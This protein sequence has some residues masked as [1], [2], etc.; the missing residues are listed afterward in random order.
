MPSKTPRARI[1]Q[2]ALEQLA[3]GGFATTSLR[4]V[5][6]KAGCT[7]GSV[8]HHFANREAL[9]VAMLREAHEAAAGRMVQRSQ[10]A[11]SPRARL[12]AVLEE[13][14]PFDEVRVREWRVWLA[15]WSEAVHV[16]ALADEHQR[17]YAEWKVL[18]GAL[19]APLVTT[20]AARE[21]AVGA[22]TALVDGLGLGLVL[23]KPGA[24]QLAAARAQ[25]DS[26]VRG[27]GR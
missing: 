8:T 21:H 4:D 17:R 18:L 20:D 27:V 13:A 22:L 10:R 1:L 9:L 26:A 15:F 3:A 14:L 6:A 11:K 12:R 23:S 25:L 2:A 16:A 24:S 7:T 19:V 5:A